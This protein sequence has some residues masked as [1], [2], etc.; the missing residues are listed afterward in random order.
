MSIPAKSFQRLSSGLKKFIPVLESARS[1]DVNESDTVVIITDMLCEIF[2]YDKYSEITTEHVIRKTFCDLAIKLNNA[3][4][5]LIEVKAIGLEL[6]EDHVRQAIDYGANSGIDWVILTNGI[7]WQIFKVTFAK[8]IDKELVY[9]L[10]LLELNI[11]DENDLEP[12]FYIS[13]DAL[14]KSFLDDFYNQKKV[15][16]KYFIG[17]MLLT[18]TV[19]DVIKRELKRVSAVIKI[20]NDEIKNIL[21]NEIIKR[22]VTDDDKANEARKKIAKSAKVTLRSG[23][24]KKEEI[25]EI[26]DTK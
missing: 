23:N 3:V 24:T 17:Q 9:Q 5:I 13:K 18:D 12:L 10:N 22:E 26:S 8:P 20:E 25:K 15:I 21:I 7:I 1:R 2:G 14:G 6:K 4:K 11:K 16:N 19:I